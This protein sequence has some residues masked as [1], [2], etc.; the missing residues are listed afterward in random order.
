MLSIRSAADLAEALDLPL[1]ANLHC[2][3]RRRADQLREYDGYELGDL[4]HLLVVEAG[5][6]L[7]IIEDELG[8]SP[9]TNAADGTHYG[10]AEFTPSWEAIEQHGSWYELV[11]VLSDD[12]FGAVVLVPEADDVDPELLALCR[13]YSDQQRSVIQSTQNA[14]GES[15]GLG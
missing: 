3:L 6:D 1:D 12:G 4:A 11:F 14:K 8:F 2:L 7:A 13:E 15:S 5:D 10:E 9:L